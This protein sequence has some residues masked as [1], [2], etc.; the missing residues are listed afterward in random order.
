[1]SLLA[2]ISQ[3]DHDTARIANVTARM[4]RACHDYGRLES[5]VE[6]VCV[7]KGFSADAIL[8][9]LEAG[10]RIFGE[11]R[12]QEAAQK[13]PKLRGKF[14][15]LKL[16]LIGPLQSNKAADAVALFDVIQTVDRPKIA[17]A[18]ADAIAK[19][20]QAPRLFIQ[21]NT[22]Q[23]SQK[24]GVAPPDLGALL[25]FCRDEAKLNI[26]G[27]MC[28]PPHDQLASPHFAFLAKLAAEFGLRDLSMGMSEDFELAIQLGA[29]YVRIGSAIFGTRRRNG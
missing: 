26:E 20:G 5:D 9:V 19:N 10:Q 17:M 18:I 6:L 2:P 4:I 7:S 12:V 28:I 24:A 25:A 1:M 13:W 29:T 11:N 15:D 21:V 3:Q 23:E 22:A 8:P 16:H 27:L 14:P